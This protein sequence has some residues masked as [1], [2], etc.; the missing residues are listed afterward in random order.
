MA[1]TA[2]GLSVLETAKALLSK[3]TTANELRICQAVIYPIEYGM[4]TEQT[5]SCIGRSAGWTT[6]NRNAFIKAGGFVKKERPGGRK[7]ANM[8]IEEEK[9]FLEP[10]LEQARVGGILVVGNIHKAL[11]EHLGRKIALAS[12]YNLLHRHNWRKLAPNKRHVDTD[13]EAQNEQ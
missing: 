8:S 2:R 12:A 4:S 13:V 1:R 10:F 11:E 3:V 9:A 7:R 6:K 5:A